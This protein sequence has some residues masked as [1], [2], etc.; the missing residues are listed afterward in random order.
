MPHAAPTSA[1]P[2]DPAAVR[3]PPSATT[4][5]RGNPNLALAPAQ[6]ARGFDPRA[7]RT[8]AG[9]PCRSPAIH[10]NYGAEKRAE[11]RFRITLPR[12]SQVGA[13]ALYPSHLPPAL[14]ARHSHQYPPEL[15]PPPRP[16]GG[17]TAAEDRTM[18]HAVAASLAPWH[19]AIAEA[20]AARRAA[21]IAARSIQ[22]AARAP[23]ADGQTRTTH[24]NTSSSPPA[25]PVPI[26]S[27]TGDSVPER[28]LATHAAEL[29][30]PAN[31]PPK[32]APTPGPTAPFKP[33]RTDPLNREPGAFPDP[34][35]QPVRRLHETG[36]IRESTQC[37]A[38]AEP[39]PQARNLC[40]R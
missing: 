24:T 12:T 36:H 1:T 39:A 27:C 3:P 30:A 21:R 7:A 40:R 37:A 13:A 28:Q 6:P 17:I 4:K 29:R 38:H 2:A 23:A 19:A 11:H 26:V 32:V 14:T 9:C 10:R 20:R 34:D 22:R 18:R 33:F 16:N 8:R 15:M 35:P 31:R 5:P 25:P